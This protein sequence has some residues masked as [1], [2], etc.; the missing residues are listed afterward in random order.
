[1][2]TELIGI[3]FA[4]FSVQFETVGD[5]LSGKDLLFLGQTFTTFKKG[6]ASLIH[7]IQWHFG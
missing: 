3:C 4:S 1:M 7:N 6:G 5:A 2:E